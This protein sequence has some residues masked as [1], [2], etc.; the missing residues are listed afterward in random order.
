[1]AEV[2]ELSEIAKRILEDEEKRTQA[3]Q[4][5][6]WD[7]SPE[8]PTAQ[9]DFPDTLREQ[10]TSPGGDFT[11][12]D[13]TWSG[14]PQPLGEET[15]LEVQPLSPD[16]MPVVFRSWLLN[17]SYR[18]QCPVDFLAAGAL[19]GASALI[20]AGSGIR[21]KRH[22][23]WEVIPNLWG[24]IVAGPGMLKTPA[25]KEV[26]KPLDKMEATAR[27]A[28]NAALEFNEADEMIFKA[29]RDAIKT[30]IAALSKSKGEKKD[31][32]DKNGKDNRD[33]RTGH[34]TA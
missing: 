9:E 32:R 23:N 11:D 2:Y 34:R 3:G 31:G 22:D 19:V 26:L 7:G 33:Q 12:C 25:L 6:N 14:N 20:G 21:P 4:A 30:Q 15:L 24:G 29:E 13:S 8:I 17:T 18:M 27:E 16:Y 10:K 28:Y 1:L 5:L